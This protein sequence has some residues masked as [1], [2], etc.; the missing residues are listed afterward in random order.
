MVGLLA[1]LGMTRLGNIDREIAETRKDLLTANR[2]ATEDATLR[3]RAEIKLESPVNLRRQLTVLMKLH[4]RL[5]PES[6]K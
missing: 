4:P 2:A 3:L 6:R 1:F 5:N